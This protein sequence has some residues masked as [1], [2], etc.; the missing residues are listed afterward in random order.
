M[1]IHDIFHIKKHIKKGI[2]KILH[3]PKMKNMEKGVV[4]FHIS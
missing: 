4:K 1:I 2:E 3:I